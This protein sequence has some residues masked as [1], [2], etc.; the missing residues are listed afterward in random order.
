MYAVG[1]LIADIAREWFGIVTTAPQAWL[2]AFAVPGFARR[3]R[4]FRNVPYAGPLI[5]RFID[6]H[7]S[8]LLERA[9]LVLLA[10]FVVVSAIAAPAL[11]M[12]RE[13]EQFAAEKKALQEQSGRPQVLI[14]PLS[15][16]EIRARALADPTN[17][18]LAEG[19]YRP[20]YLIVRSPDGEAVLFN[21]RNLP[22]KAV[23]RALRVYRK[24]WFIDEANRQ[25]EIELPPPPSARE[26]L[27]P[28]QTVVR[29]LNLPKGTFYN[30]RR[31]Y[32]RI[33]LVVTYQGHQGQTAD[34]YFYS[35]ML[36]V[37][38]REEPSHKLRDLDLE[39]TDEGMLTG[40]PGRLLD[41]EAESPSR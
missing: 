10:L 29:P 31:G 30:A 3:L 38:L 8:V 41:S 39:S 16:A 7:V 35:V 32:V 21:V 40:D 22:G 33:K 5:V 26:V 24:V 6:S 4:K 1:V 25:H 18:V 15:G 9:C 20:A 11:I 28:D 37:P 23:A 12:S 36:K 2:W 34:S 13:R 17:P 19:A 14:E 27:Y